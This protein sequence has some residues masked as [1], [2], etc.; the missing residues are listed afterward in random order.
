M[1]FKGGV[2]DARAL[3]AYNGRALVRHAGGACGAART[4]RPES[5]SDESDREQAQGGA[6]GCKDNASADGQ[7]LE[8]ILDYLAPQVRVVSLSGSGG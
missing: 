2:V 5:R 1:A 8:A 4:R 7:I 3:S 6:E